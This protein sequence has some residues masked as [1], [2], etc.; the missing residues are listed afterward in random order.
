MIVHDVTVAS[1][2]VGLPELHQRVADR[3]AVL[4][5][6]AAADDD[7]LAERLAGVLAG[8]IGVGFTDRAIAIDRA[9]RNP[10]SSRST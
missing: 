2:G 9:R 7:A 3:P 5:Q 8:Q 4:V 10:R 1:G 6:H